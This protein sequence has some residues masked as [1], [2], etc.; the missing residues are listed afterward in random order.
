MLFDQNMIIDATTGSIARFVNHSCRPNCQMI[1]WIVSGQP[2]MALFAGDRPIQTGDELTYDYN[3]DPFSAKN[4]QK[5]LCGADNCRGVLGPKP[6]EVKLPKPPQELK[7]GSKKSAKRKLVSGSG[8]KGSQT[9][10]KK[11]KVKTPAKLQGKIPAK[12]PIKTI[13]AATAAMMVKKSVSKISVK[14]KAVAGAKTKVATIRKT[15]VVKTVTKGKAATTKAKSLTKNASPKKTITKKASS[16]TI[17]AAGADKLKQK[18]SPVKPK[19][20]MAAAKGNG[21]GVLGKPKKMAPIKVRKLTTKV[22]KTTTPKKTLKS[23]TLPAAKA[24]SSK[25][26]IKLVKSPKA[27]SSISVEAQAALDDVFSNVP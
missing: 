21:V 13:K 1:K 2:R 19:K 27:S 3:F 5:C 4:V 12:G 24:R 7:K 22:T 20:S 15:S 23:K 11:R 14:S 25:T 10:L 18:V 8:E 26:T 9:P 17:V 6:K 16:T